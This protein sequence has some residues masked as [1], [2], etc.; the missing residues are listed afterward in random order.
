MRT[1]FF[2]LGLLCFSVACGHS[3]TGGADAGDGIGPQ[4]GTVPHLYFAVVGDTRPMN[5]DDVGSYPTAII[6]KIYADIAAM[7]PQPQFVISTGDYMNAALT[8]SQQL[9]LYLTAA[10]Q[11]TGGPLFPVMGNHECTGATSSNCAGNF[12][13]KNYQAYMAQMASLVGESQPY[14]VVNFNG[15]GKAWTA[16]LVVVACNAWDATQKT[17]LQSELAKPTTYTIVARHEEIGAS[18]GPPCLP[19]ADTIIA[20]NPYSVLLV[21]HSHYFQYIGFQK[22]VIIGNGGAPLYSTSAHYGY[23]TL[24]QQSGGFLTTEYD[25]QT[26]APLQSFTIPY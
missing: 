12:V 16:K 23:A 19:D 25:Y 11:F 7:N 13:T 1:L 21:G 24:E 5:S 26:A 3:A 10:K 15:D 6:T 14:Y 9:D 20:Q 4:G 17:W 8:A 22:E 2:G 18:S